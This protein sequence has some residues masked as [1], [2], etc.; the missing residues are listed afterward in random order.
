M[1]I[2]DQGL[3]FRRRIFSEERSRV[4][5][6]NL[7]AQNKNNEEDPAL[8]TFYKPFKNYSNSNS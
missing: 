4:A 5:S 8:L 3:V 1:K 2:C 7:A 6:K